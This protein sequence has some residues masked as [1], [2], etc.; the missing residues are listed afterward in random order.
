MSATVNETG[1]TEQEEAAMLVALEAVGPKPVR[2]LLP[3]RI[4]VWR[5]GRGRERCYRFEGEVAVSK[6]F[7]GLASIESCGISNG[8][9]GYLPHPFEHLVMPF[10]E[11]IQVRV[12]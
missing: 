2:K 9:A 1:F 11:E 12:A 8:E 7:N 4:R 6:L 10:A 5:E 3:N